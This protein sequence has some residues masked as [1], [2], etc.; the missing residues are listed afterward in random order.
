MARL[1]NAGFTDY[2]L[3][4]YPPN[5]AAVESY[6]F[7]T[8][9]FISYDGTE[10]RRINRVA[11]RHSL[12]YNIRKSVIGRQEIYNDIEQNIRGKWAMPIWPDIQFVGD[13]TGTTVQCN[14]GPFQFQVGQLVLAYTRTN[15]W[16]TRVITN[17]KSNIIVVSIAFDDMADAFIMPCNSALITGDVSFNMGSADSEFNFTY[18]ETMP[19][20]KLTRIA[21]MF[22][23]DKSL[24]MAGTS[25]NWTKACITTILNELKSAITNSG[26]V[27]DLAI[28][29]WATTAAT[30]SWLLATEADI[31]S[32]IALIAAIT[33][34]S[35]TTPSPNNPFTDANTFFGTT[36]SNPT[37]RTDFL[38]YI[39]NSAQSTISAAIT[40]SALISGSAPYNLYKAVKIFSTVFDH[41]SG[42]DT[43]QALRVDNASNGVLTVLS[44]SHQDSLVTTFS[45]AVQID[46][47]I[48]FGGYEILT[49][50]ADG[51]SLA[52]KA[53]MIS[54]NIDFGG[55]FETR[56]PWLVSRIGAIQ[57]FLLDGITEVYNF[58][59]FMYRRQGKARPFYMPSFQHDLNLTD[60]SN[61]KTQGFIGD[62]DFDAFTTNR[63][64]V[65]ISYIDGTWQG[66]TITTVTPEVLG[67]QLTFAKPLL[68]A[69]DQIFQISYMG[70]ARLDSDIITF[71][72]IG[73]QAVTV[74]LNILEIEK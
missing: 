38:F 37:T 60:L 63:R 64:T 12:K 6:S 47:G 36:S 32:A 7:D 67:F 27:I 72:W 13:I 33:T 30:T 53:T 54:E 4:P 56:T 40:A 18:I 48:Q 68:Q 31:D 14:T 62:I 59:R 50:D 3:L 2:A 45:N 39:T 29:Q 51:D 57:T 69:M 8:D 71:N 5:G 28:C 19:V 24:S 55:A 42:Y 34:T 17:V 10:N 46:I 26:I 21:V 16:Q 61:D 9:I 41:G 35:E 49:T 23:I 70:L 20:P 73:N 1:V 58:K 43:V 65:V 44:S 52:K 74:S 25:I 15:E 66:N 11:A 22:L